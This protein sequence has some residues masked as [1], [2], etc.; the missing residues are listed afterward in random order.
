MKFTSLQSLSST[1]FGRTEKRFS[2]K[3]FWQQSDIN[4]WNSCD[5]LC[6]SFA[7]TLRHF[8]TLRPLMCSKF[9]ARKPNLRQKCDNTIRAT[10][11][12]HFVPTTPSGKTPFTTAVPRIT[13]L[14]GAWPVFSPT[15]PKGHKHRVTTP[16]NPQKS[17]APPQSPAETPQNPRSAPRMVTLQNFSF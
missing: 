15:G 3:G 7:T 6:D 5:A 14:I 2:P 17:R 10:S 8:E 16:E 12:R 9:L 13:D 4:L 11:L 1:S